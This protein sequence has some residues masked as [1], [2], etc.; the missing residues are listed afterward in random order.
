MSEAT[1]IFNLNQDWNRSREQN[2]ISA[3][4]NFWG[5]CK[6]LNNWISTA[7]KNGFIVNAISVSS[8]LAMSTYT[9][10]TRCTILNSF[11]FANYG[12][13]VVVHD[14]EERLSLFIGKI[15]ISYFAIEDYT[16]SM[17]HNSIKMRILTLFL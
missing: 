12:M 9:F 1:N 11:W 2:L 4:F 17:K 6:L 5:S 13:W 14:E 3:D 8:Q 10:Y 15:I 16:L 7:N